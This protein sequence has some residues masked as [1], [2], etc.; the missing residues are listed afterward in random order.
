[1]RVLTCSCVAQLIG[2]ACFA[3]LLGGVR[4]AAHVALDTGTMEYSLIIVTQHRNLLDIRTMLLHK[5]TNLRNF[6]MNGV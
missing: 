2:L 3:F 4:L 5:F 6:D 1:M